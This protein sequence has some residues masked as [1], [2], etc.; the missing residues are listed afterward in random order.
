MPNHL[1]SETSPYLLQHSHNPV[2]WYP[3]GE[4]ALEK[5]HQEDKP[6][7]LSIGYAACH[8]CH[9]MAHESFEDPET[10]RLMNAHFVNIKVDREERPDLDSIYMSAVVSMTGQGGWP[11]S[12]FLTPDG[13]PFY[14]GTYFPPVSRYGMPGFKDVLVAIDRVW[15]EDREQAF[16]VSAQLVEHLRLNSSWGSG[17]SSSLSLEDLQSAQNKL[18]SSY[19]WQ[20]GG[21][22]GAPRFPAP[23]SIEFLLQQGT[24]GQ[25]EAVKT[26]LHALK[27]M[28]RGGMYDIVG[29]GFHRYSTDD[30]WLVPHFEKMLYDNAQLAH[31]YLHAYLLTGETSFMHTCEETLEF[32][33]RE[34]THPQGGFYSSLDADSAGQ[35]G[36][37]YI[38]SLEE[39]EHTVNNKD[40]LN[41][42]LKMY[43]VTPG[44]NFEG[45]N[46]LQKRSTED[47]IA[48]DLSIPVES[49]HQRLE[50]IRQL[51]Y[52][53]RSK[54]TRP[55]TDDK[56]LVAWNGLVLRVL[57]EAGSALN[58]DDFLHAAQKNADFL[59]NNLYSKN[60]LHRSWRNGHAH[61]N[62]F[63][64]DYAALCLGLFALYQADGNTQWYRW[65]V[66]LVEEMKTS[67]NDPE[68]GFF[69]TRH[70]HATLVV[71]PK[72]M[73]DNAV[74][75][76]N[77]LAVMALLQLA[78]FSGDLQVRESAEKTI[79]ALKNH[80]L[81]YPSAFSFWL[82]A[83]D[84]AVGPVQQIAVVWKAENTKPIDFLNLFY[85]SY[86][87][88]AVLA[89]GPIPAN[90]SQP[91]LLHDRGAINDSATAYVCQKFICLRPATT[92]EEFGSLLDSS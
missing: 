47:Q 5:A 3:W 69:D 92:L 53:A 78:E 45:K 49:V 81:E 68:G 23:M 65:A 44:G 59:L 66:R 40:D 62:A 63:L 88:R 72:G 51:L 76:G 60:R 85:Q 80:C 16:H 20:Y 4:E 61:H 34:M 18:I 33:L 2:D 74:P 21:W 56:T 50:N 25:P 86:R 32:L 83:M 90:G 10:A 84:F 8:W 17:D 67:F 41:L 19:D 48:S 1:A 28:Q 77:S 64:E 26:A 55:E 13:E 29:G 35:E 31:V 71:R 6:I 58:R 87:P 7:F 36:L 82:Q 52:I 42:F 89:E 46:I 15:R 14:G 70:D 38:W 91:E 79:L 11:M 43:S 54:R 73:Q 24:R 30:R 27:A 39:I 75:S 57:A 22:G 12:V 9:V 37:F